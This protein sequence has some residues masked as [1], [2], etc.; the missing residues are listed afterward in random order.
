[1]AYWRL[2]YAT[3]WPE[4]LGFCLT[5][6]PVCLE[7][8]TVSPIVTKGWKWEGLL[9]LW[10]WVTYLQNCFPSLCNSELCWFQG[11]SS[12]G[13]MPRWRHWIKTATWP[14]WSPYCSEN[15][16]NGVAVT[17]CGRRTMY[18]SL[19]HILVLPCKQYKWM[20]NYRN[21]HKMGPLRI[22]TIQQWRFGSLHQVKDPNYIPF[23]LKL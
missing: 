6:C 22:Q 4:R 17:Q 10:Q 11:C 8:A 5:R 7:S 15:R 2:G 19:R 23:Y 18:A 12:D 14:C 13:G 20:E 16:G 21:Q 1:M 3:I 9:S